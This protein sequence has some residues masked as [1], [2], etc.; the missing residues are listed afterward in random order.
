M[1][2]T[3]S[4]TNMFMRP[5]WVGTMRGVYFPASTQTTCFWWSNSGSVCV[6]VWDRRWCV[7]WFPLHTV[8]PSWSTL[9]MKPSCTASGF[10]ER[11][12]PAPINTHH[13]RHISQRWPSR[14]R[15]KQGRREIYLLSTTICD[16]RDVKESQ[17]FFGS[18]CACL[19]PSFRANSPAL[20]GQSESDS[21]DK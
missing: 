12:V 9:Q 2:K 11:S 1:Y 18:R 15:S 10:P 13:V 16:C 21:V 19:I 3:L 5:S 14:S 8:D 20:H 4:V 7:R 17:W 6:C